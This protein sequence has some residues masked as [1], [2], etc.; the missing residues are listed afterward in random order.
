MERGGERWRESRQELVVGVAATIVVVVKRK[1]LNVARDESRT[2]AYN[3]CFG[4]NKIVVC[5]CLL[6]NSAP[7]W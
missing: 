5:N 7:W 6:A 4:L 1:P 3:V 2:A